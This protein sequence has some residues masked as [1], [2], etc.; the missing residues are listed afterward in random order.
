MESTLKKNQAFISDLKEIDGWIYQFRV[1][2]YKVVGGKKIYGAWSEPYTMV[3]TLDVE[4]AYKELKQYA[5]DYAAK[6]Y[7]EWRYI[8]EDESEGMNDS[9]SS[10]YIEGVLGGSSMYVRQEDFVKRYK[11]RIENYIDRMK[12]SG[13]Q[14]E[15]F[16][17]IKR[18]RP[19]DS[20]GIW[21]NNSV[22][23]FYEVWML[24]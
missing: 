14:Q 6:N 4:A 2:A 15:G 21:T 8:G 12:S 13:G 24:Y 17:Y 7:P 20:E 18:V 22:Q 11:K 1:R 19:E 5:I 16:I 9:N 23:T 3:E 10:Y